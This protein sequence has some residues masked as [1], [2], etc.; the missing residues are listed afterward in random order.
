MKTI[1][2]LI[3]AS[4][5]VAS[6]GQNAYQRRG[7]SLS[8]V[9]KP[10]P[11]AT[12]KVYPMRDIPA[13]DPRFKAVLESVMS[14]VKK[15]E[16]RENRSKIIE[17]LQTVAPGEFLVKTNDDSRK[18]MV[19]PGLAVA[20][21]KA[22]YG[23]LKPRKGL[24]TYTS[25]LGARSTAE[26]FD[27]EPL[28]SIDLDADKFIAMLKG[29]LKIEIAKGTVDIPCQPCSGWGRL[30]ETATRRTSQDGKTECVACK[31]IGKLTVPQRVSVQW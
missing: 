26:S 25:V 14:E 19:A 13:D 18:H 17:I 31:G 10:R 23:N 29:G 27:Y 3:L 12:V 30:A 16:I 6:L 2:L 8:P 1:S 7:M 11:E 5:T 22:I 21:G 28:E 4:L 9:A 20:D 15:Q 24:Y